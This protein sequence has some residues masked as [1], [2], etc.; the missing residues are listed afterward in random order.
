[1]KNSVSVHIHMNGNPKK[2]SLD[3]KDVCHTLSEALDIL[4]TAATK[5]SLSSQG[6]LD[7]MC[8]YK[9]KKITSSTSLVELIVV[10][11]EEVAEF[12]TVTAMDRVISL[13]EQSEPKCVPM[14]MEALYKEYNR[15][16]DK[17]KQGMSRE[18]SLHEGA[19]CWTM[20]FL[21]T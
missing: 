17:S 16:N 8:S 11:R 13:W 7:Y 21:D 4:S 10:I 15:R 3:I 9:C 6:E 18:R 19:R 5:F 20:S 2:S 1:M 14:K 12:K